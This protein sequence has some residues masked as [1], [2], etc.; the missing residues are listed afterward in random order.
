MKR[1]N[2]QLPH[3]S[4]GCLYHWLL[5]AMWLRNLNLW[6]EIQFALPDVQPQEQRC[7]LLPAVCAVLPC[8]QI[9]VL[10]VSEIVN[11]CTD[12]DAYDCTR[13]LYEDRKRVC[14]H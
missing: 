3:P 4:V 11:V 5:R 1:C 13:G 8:V 12:V 2:V 6:R 9:M 14:L 10:P 7:P